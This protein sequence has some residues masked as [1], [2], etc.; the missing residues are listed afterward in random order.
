MVAYD[1]SEMS[2]YRSSSFKW[3]N[4]LPHI[5]LHIT[6]ILC[7]IPILMHFNEEPKQIKIQSAND[8]LMYAYFFII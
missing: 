8:L 4:L 3:S 7:K 5:T 1:Q 6:I 2:G